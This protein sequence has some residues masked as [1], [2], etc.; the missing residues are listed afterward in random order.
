MQ[1]HAVDESA[2]AE[3]LRSERLAGLRVRH[4]RDHPPPAR[5]D[6]VALVVR[7]A[8]V[9]EAVPLEG[10]E[11]LRA[12]H[13]HAQ[14]LEALERLQGRCLGRVV[15]PLADQLLERPEV[16]HRPR[17]DLRPHQVPEP[18]DEHLGRSVEALF[19]RRGATPL[20]DESAVRLQD[21]RAPDERGVRVVVPVPQRQRVHD[22][23]GQ[24][25][26]AELQGAAVGHERGG[27]Q[28]DHVVGRRHRLLRRREQRRRVAR[29]V[30]DHVERVGADLGVPGHVRQLVVDHPDH[31]DRALARRL[32]L[33][34]HRDQLEAGV[35]V[36]REAVAHPVGR[37]AL[38]HHLHRDVAAEA[39]D[40]ARGEGVVGGDVVP[41]RRRA[42]HA[43]A[44]PEVEL[45]DAY[46]RRQRVGRDV[47]GVVELDHAL[48]DPV[49]QGLDERLLQRGARCRD[50]QR[51]RRQDREADAGVGL[52]AGV[53]RVDQL[54]RLAEPER[55]PDLEVRADALDDRVDAALDVIQHRGLP[56]R[57]G[58]C[59][60]GFSF[61]LSIQARKGAAASALR[62]TDES[63]SR[64][65]PGWAQIRRLPPPDQEPP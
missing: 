49:E 57:R 27:V 60:H 56:A 58:R 20:V 39:H 10:V 14:R 38:R 46:V 4:V 15:E 43:A 64:V 9:E 2:V 30:D 11:V 50:L 24:R 62:A 1:H 8:V 40:V 35:G 25:A 44:G 28:P 41:L 13:A 61:D 65:L 17:Q 7:R 3:A 45:L 23:V 42:A 32:G 6:D 19:E 36:A 31:G 18:V 26:D 63:V 59:A 54:R 5:R 37:L 33:A 34:H 51:Q 22:R 52:R 55:Q 29:V 53:Q 48:E 21:P 12:Q 16:V 47:A